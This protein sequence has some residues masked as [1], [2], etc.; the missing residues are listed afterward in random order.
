[1]SIAAHGNGYLQD[2]QPWVLIK[3]N[4]ERCGTV[5]C[6]NSSLPIPSCYLNSLTLLQS[7]VYSCASCSPRCCTPM[8]PM[9]ATAYSHSS[10]LSSV[11]LM[12][13]V[14]PRRKNYS[15]NVSFLLFTK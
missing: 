8:R 2:E 7:C 14:Y 3:S 4:A 6:M 15:I 11:A 13:Y 1:M 9:S 5:V 12:T 10:T